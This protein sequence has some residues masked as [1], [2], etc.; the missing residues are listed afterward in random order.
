MDDIIRLLALTTATIGLS[1]SK[2]WLIIG[3]TQWLI[4]KS[5]DC[6]NNLTSLER[7]LEYSLMQDEEGSNNA[8]SKTDKPVFNRKNAKQNIDQIIH[9]K[10]E[11][12]EI[13]QDGRIELKSFCYGYKNN[14]TVLNDI[15]IKILSGEKIGIVGRT[16]AGKSSLISAL[17]RMRK[18]Q[19]GTVII[20]TKDAITDMSLL[21]LRRNLSIIPQE[22]FIFCDTFRRNIDPLGESNDEK[23]WNVLCNVGLADKVKSCTGG[24]DYS[25]VERGA[26][27]SVGEK[28]L[29]CLARATLKHNKILLIGEYNFLISIKEQIV[30]VKTRLRQ[31]WICKQ[32]NSFNKHLQKYLIKQQL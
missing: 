10:D 11:K 16:G 2:S 29:L 19:S 9:R 7:I 30:F 14:V 28:Q 25:L 17:F 4:K 8:N 15:S 24:L 12:T 20:S 26:N 22:P 13:I 23:L 31:M 32:T 18:P 5:C 6:E 21:E 27:L 1:L 3:N